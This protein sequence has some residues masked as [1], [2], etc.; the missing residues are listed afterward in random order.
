MQAI[1]DP[2]RFRIH[3][4]SS[5]AAVKKQVQPSF[6]TASLIRD[7][8]RSQDDVCRI[9]GDEFAVIM[10]H[11]DTSQAELVRGKVGRINENLGRDEGDLP[12]TF[13]SCGAAYGADAA[14]FTAVFQNA[15]A[16]LYRVKNRGGGGCEVA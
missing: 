4:V 8:F 16:A 15:D 6:L 11:T 10:G 9:G 12:G 2:R 14:N 3:A 7:S 5:R 1:S 13:V